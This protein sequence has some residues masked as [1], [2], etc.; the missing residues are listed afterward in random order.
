MVSGTLEALSAAARHAAPEVDWRSIVLLAV[1]FDAH[2][3]FERFSGLLAGI[4]EVNSRS[5]AGT[6]VPGIV[7]FGLHDPGQFEQLVQSYAEAA[8]I[9]DWPG[10]AY[11]K[12]PSSVDDLRAAAARVL[13]GR[14]TPIPRRSAAELLGHIGKVLH[15]FERVKQG[16]SGTARIFSDVER[17]RLVLT[18]RILRPAECLSDRQSFSIKNLSLALHQLGQE[19][20]EEMRAEL[21]HKQLEDLNCASAALEERKA[22]LLNAPRHPEVNELRELALIS[23]R[24][25]SACAELYETMIGLEAKLSE[26]T[27]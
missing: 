1:D 25:E 26:P 3:K 9:L 20:A 21:L 18:D 15:W 24:L 14:F 19:Q 12:M 23:R 17:G 10:M 4:N 13:M 7:L 8:W 16:Q 22:R 2:G 5:G 27:G 11:L 6:P